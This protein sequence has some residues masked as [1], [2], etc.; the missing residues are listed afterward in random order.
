MLSNNEN[1]LD[2]VLHDI[3][4]LF[5]FLYLCSG[6]PLHALCE[7]AL[8]VFANAFFY[9]RFHWIVYVLFFARPCYCIALCL[10]LSSAFSTFFLQRTDEREDQGIL[11][12]V[13]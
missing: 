6:R 9:A 4:L 12:R 10:L 13:C 8:S 11:C 1:K 5:S 2:C 7:R 3:V